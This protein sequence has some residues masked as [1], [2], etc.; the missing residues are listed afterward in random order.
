MVKS[1]FSIKGFYYFTRVVALKCSKCFVFKCICV[2][3][4]SKVPPL[5]VFVLMVVCFI[6]ILSR[7]YIY[8]LI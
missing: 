2:L 7:T 4:V 3:D 8:M 1:Y 5:V 6:L